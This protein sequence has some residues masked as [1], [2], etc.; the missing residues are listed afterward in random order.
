MNRMVAAL[1]IVLGATGLARAQDEERTMAPDD[2][3]AY[4]VAPA[5]GATVSSPVTVIFGLRGMGVAP[6]GVERLDTGHHHLLIDTELPPLDEPIPFSQNLM[7]FGSGQTEVELE[8]PPGQHKL[9]LL[10][11]DLNHTPHDPPIVSEP[12]TITVE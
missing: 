7:H 10:L 1:A 3:M 9:Q 11:G 6:A 8:L 12:I 5:D 2:A 4:I